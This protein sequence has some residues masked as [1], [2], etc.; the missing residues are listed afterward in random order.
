MQQTMQAQ[1]L[2]R[3]AERSAVAFLLA[4]LCAVSYTHIRAHE[5]ALDF[6]CRLLLEKKKNPETGRAGV[7]AVHNDIT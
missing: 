5:T 3:M 7:S 6:V 1:Q 4:V 2:R